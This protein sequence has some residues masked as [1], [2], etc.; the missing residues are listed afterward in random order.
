MASYENVSFADQLASV[1][2]L[3]IKHNQNCIVDLDASRY[4]ALIMPLIEHLRFSPLMKAMRM[5]DN[6]SLV[7]LYKAYSTSIYIKTEEIINLEVSSYR[8]LITKAH[9]YKLLGLLSSDV[10]VDPDSITETSM[11]EMFYQ[12]GYTFD[13]SLLSNFQK[14]FLSLIWNNLFFVQESIR[15]GFG[16]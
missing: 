2:M 14:T 11:I 3:N 6:V 9:F 4:N 10:G 5:H 1:I 15:E 12:M 7:H 13:I 16:L 8:N